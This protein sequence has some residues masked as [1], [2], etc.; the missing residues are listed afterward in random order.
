MFRA[1]LLVDLKGPFVNRHYLMVRGFRSGRYNGVSGEDK[2]E[3]AGQP[4]P[5]KPYKFDLLAG[6]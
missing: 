3:I 5:G 4:F 6:D 1:D 2:P